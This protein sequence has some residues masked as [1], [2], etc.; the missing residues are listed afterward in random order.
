MITIAELEQDKL[1]I[2]AEI[3]A[4][5]G[6]DYSEEIEAKVAAYRE[7]LEQEYVAKNADVL[8]EKKMELK[9]IDRIIAKHVEVETES[10]EAVQAEE[11]QVEPA[12]A[13]ITEE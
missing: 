11:E 13:I 1:D 6:Q 8:A 2:Q 10:P 9:A 12:T 5:E 4:I 7:Q 3:D